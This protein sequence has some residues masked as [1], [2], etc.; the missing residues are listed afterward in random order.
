MIGAISSREK[1]RGASQTAAAAAATRHS[2]TTGCGIGVVADG[3]LALIFVT[4]IVIVVFVVSVVVVV[5]PDVLRSVSPTEST[6]S[7]LSPDGLMRS[8]ALERFAPLSARLASGDRFETQRLFV[9]DWKTNG[10]H[11]WTVIDHS[12][13]DGSKS[14]Q[15]NNGPLYSKQNDR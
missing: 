12:E 6:S 3:N 9:S 5:I 4:P 14:N 8:D 7:Q 13:D 11:L 1:S 10:T 2:Q 15:R